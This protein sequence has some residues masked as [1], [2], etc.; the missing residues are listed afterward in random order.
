MAFEALKQQVKALGG[1]RSTGRKGLRGLDEEELRQVAGLI[2]GELPPAWKWW[3]STFGDGV[4]FV[5]PVVY[6]D[7]KAK[8]DVLIGYFMTVDEMRQTIDDLEGSLAARRIPFIDDASGDYLV[9]DLE[10]AVAWHLHDRPRDRNS[11]HVA[12]SF[13]AFIRMLRRGD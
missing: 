2:G 7:V 11:E 13:E 1:L 5:E 8:T 9:M 3:L 4:K 6:D 12:G 10:G